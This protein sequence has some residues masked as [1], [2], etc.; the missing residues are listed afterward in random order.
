MSDSE[1]VIEY[2]LQIED[3]LHTLQSRLNEFAE[4]KDLDDF[5]KGRQLAYQEIMEIIQTRHKMIMD[6]LEE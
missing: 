4:E 5:E 2:E 1:K 3:M 6:V